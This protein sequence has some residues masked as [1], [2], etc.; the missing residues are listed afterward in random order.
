MTCESVAWHGGQSGKV[1]GVER[2][3][4]W[5]KVRVRGR[6]KNH[7]HTHTHTHRS[8]K[9]RE[10]SFKKTLNVLAFGV[11][12]IPKVEQYCSKCQ[13]Y[14]AFE[15][16]GASDFLLC[17]ILNILHFFFFLVNWN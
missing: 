5:L 16:S 9:M 3:E 14:L 15:K 13:S 17:Q 2:L 11:C 6:E 8:V 1:G 10:K 7:T 12:T 4:A